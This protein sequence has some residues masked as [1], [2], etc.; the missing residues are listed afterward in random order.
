MA[1]LNNACIYSFVE[2]CQIL[3]YYCAILH[4]TSSVLKCLLTVLPTQYVNTIC[5]DFSSMTGKKDI[6]VVLICTYSI[7]WHWEGFYMFVG[8]VYIFFLWTV[9]IGRGLKI[10]IWLDYICCAWSHCHLQAFRITFI[11]DESQ[12]QITWFPMWI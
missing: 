11:S 7:L 1:E 3:H 9:C 8:H 2:H 5:F 6:N 4:T 12:F 10:Y